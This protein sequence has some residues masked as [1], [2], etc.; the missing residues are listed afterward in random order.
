MSS[1]GRIAK[2]AAGIFLLCALA[3]GS[4]GREEEPEPEY[5][6]LPT[7]V[8]VPAGDSRNV[9]YLQCDFAEEGIYMVT[10]GMGGAVS[11]YD[12][13]SGE[14]Q[15]LFSLPD[16]VWAQ[17]I[18]AGG[19][20][21]ER[22][23][24]C[25]AEVYGKDDNGVINPKDI[26]YALQCYSDQG[27]LLWE[28]IL[29]EYSG[30]KEL[31]PLMIKLITA[32]DGR[33]FVAAD[34]YL[35]VFSV[36]GEQIGRVEY[37][38]DNAETS[39]ASAVLASDKEGMVYLVAL[40]RPPVGGLEDLG[41]YKIYQWNEEA[42]SLDEM[43]AVEGKMPLQAAG[44]TGLFFH[45]RITAYIY[46]TQSGEMEP[47]FSLEENLISY[48]QID[49][50]L[51]QE[52][53]WEMLL[54]VNS[55]MQ[56]V[57]LKWGPKEEGRFLSIASVSVSSDLNQRILLFNQRHPEY[58]LQVRAY[59]TNDYQ[60]RLQQIQLSLVGKNPP[61]LVE[62]W[63]TREYL[64]YARK[65]WLE[66]LT[67]YVEKSENISLE[68]FVPRLREAMTVQGGFYALPQEFY[69]STLAIPKSLAEGRDSWD[70]EEFLDFMEAYPNAYFVVRG[71]G[72]QDNQ[73]ERKKSILHIALRR[74]LAGFVDLERGKVDLDN[75]RFRSLLARV[76]GL[77]IDENL[78]LSKNDLE[79]RVSDGEIL[80]P[81]VSLDSANRLLWLEDEQRREMALIGYPGAER[82]DGGGIIY[83]STPTG[84]SSSSR[85]KE[86]AWSYLE[87]LMTEEADIEYASGFPARQEQLENMLRQMHDKE[88]AADEN[89]MWQRYADMTRGAIDTAVLEDPTVSQLLGIISEEATDYFSGVKSLDEV[90]DIMESRAELYFNENK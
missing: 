19:S 26:S 74:G 46:N 4:C 33:V 45:D 90:I 11:L 62:V 16:N 3:L 50:L 2:A 37:P 82:E 65:G 66:D 43:A 27:Q 49:K 47:A 63:S 38:I 57:S 31:S 24:L 85:N 1:K 55:G 7:F 88:D 36:Q 53:G 54:H 29:D 87:E 8:S 68:D 60:D 28:N 72:L 71:S 15:K 58:L 73:T 64:N 70:I 83:I 32:E 69:I 41:Q 14:K 39:A 67:T 59:G 84:I 40:S 34:T 75:D 77:R 20:D 61:D 25:A 89:A 9:S 23:F 76:D 51:A 78:G 30:D 44:G 10:S 56:T 17:K 6:Y 21:R 86:G 22:L 12:P 5:G 52:N 18:L 35:Y 81:A 42:Q 13:D 79:R 48:Y 80:M